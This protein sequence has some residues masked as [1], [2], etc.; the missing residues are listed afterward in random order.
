MKQRLYL[1]L[2]ACAL[3]DTMTLRA[4]IQTN[5]G[6]QYLQCMQKDVSTDFYDLSN[7]YFLADSIVSF[8]AA[9]GEGLVNWK[10]YRMS[11]RQAFNLNGY[12]PVRMQMLDFPDAAYDNDPN[13]R[14]SIE[15]VSPKAARIRMLTTPVIPDNKDVDDPM[16]GDVFKVRY[17]SNV[18]GEKVEIPCWP[19]TDNGNSVVYKSENGSIEIQRFPFRIVL[20]DAKGKI[21]T[22]TRHIIDNDS[23]QVKLL[24]LSFIK[25]GSDNSRSVNPVFLLSP[26]ERIYGCGES[27]TSLNKVGQKVHL[28]V[29]DPQGPETDGMYKPVPF[30]FSNRGYGI[31]MHTSAP[32]T[33]D[34]GAS[35][36]GAQRLFMADEQIDLFVFFGSP[37]EILDEYTNVTG[38]S[39][40]PPLWSF[41]TWM[42]RI[43][44][45]SQEEGLEIAHQLR[46]H[47]IP[48]DVIH[49][50]TGWFGV[51]WQCDYEFA[52]DRFKD[53]EGMLKQL[54]KDGFHTCL[55]Q[56]PYFTPKNRFFTEI[57]EKGLHV[58]NAAGGMPVEDAILDFSNPETVSWYQSKITNLLKQGVSTIKCDF[59]EAAPYNG[60]YHSGLGGLYEHNLYPL[61][62]NKALWEAVNRQYFG[63]GIIWA[64]SAWAGSQRYALHWG[65]DA[66]TNNIGMLGD[67]RGGLSFGLSGFSF[68]SHDMGGFVT[69][70]PEDIYCRWL[71]FGFLSSHTRAHGAPPTEPWLISESFTKAFRECAEMKYKLMPYVYAQAK[72]CSERGLPMVRALL[73]EFPQDP[74]AWLVEDEYMFGSQMLVAP[75]LESG[76]E[77]MVYLPQGKWIDYQSGKV[78]E[79]GYQTIPAG[80]IPAV[81]LVR[82]GSLIPHAPLAQ[83]TDQINW[84]KIELKAYK[85]DAKKCTG[86]LFKP[87]DKT[88]K[89]IVQ[90]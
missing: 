38:K 19:S 86:I 32:V 52:K 68:W 70:S 26:G 43:T 27:F 79:G 4:Q 42:S 61:R 81:I 73:V 24:P 53:P 23:T 69:A 59:G 74:G 49:F 44:Y 75:L 60:I 30:Y 39:L 63:E 37:K 65:G 21:L 34:F 51:D 87:G 41:G 89:N 78:Y 45:F 47:K 22:Q 29:T 90:P 58:K 82:D 71:P 15:F 48:S 56:L 46:A 20:K 2:A 85:A 55:W 6:V 33:A 62:Y 67:L 76:N 9:K 88:I 13:L 66:A 84:N 28:S 50:D 54:A 10:R 57:V 1:M 17:Y 83:R 14:I 18:N 36:I 80:K 8:D 5:A 3:C 12:W 35:Y 40:M 16:F 77:R 72:D 11:P 31:F 64:R 7:T 25:R